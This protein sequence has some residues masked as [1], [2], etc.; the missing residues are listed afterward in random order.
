[1]NTKFE[2]IRK[3]T[4]I[5]FTD[6][7]GYTAMMQ[8]DEEYAKTIRDKHRDVL[9]SKIK[10][11]RGKILQ[12][13]GDGTLSVFDSAIEAVICSKEIQTELLEQPKIPL[14]I[15][16]H[17][18]DIVHDKDG[19]YGDGVNVAS[20][21]QSLCTPGSVMISEKVQAEITNHP[22]IKSLALGS[23]E[24]KNVQKPVKVFALAGGKIK[25]PT[26]QEIQQQ[27][28]KSVIK[29]SIAVL[30]FINMS[31]DSENDYF[32]DGIAEEIMNG[33]NKLE[34]IT[35]TSRT[36]SFAFRGK[37]KSINEIGSELKVSFVLEGSV[38]KNADD[39]RVMIQLINT[40]DEYQLW[41]EVYE[42]KLNNVFE[43]QDE[44]ARNVVHRLKENL[45]IKSSKTKIIERPTKNIDAYNLY[46]KGRHHWSKWN[47]DDIQKAI[48]VFDEAIRLDPKF[49]L[50]YCA[51]S[52]CYSFLG[53]CG[54]LTPSIAYTKA[55]EF[56]LE[57]IQRNEN[58]AES[59]L[60]LAMIKFF[61]LWD[62]EGARVSLEKAIKLNLNSSLLNQIYGLYLATVGKTKEAIE[63]MENAVKLD[64]LSLSLLC[65]L[66]TV[67]FFDA[68]YGR[69]ISYFDAALDMD[70][71]FRMALE[72]KGVTL[73][74]I[75]ETEAS[76]EH[77][78]EY[79]K[80]TKHPLKGMSI[81]GLVYE[82][83][84]DSENANACL[85]K[86]IQRQEQEPN[87]SLEL[88]FAILYYGLKDYDKVFHYL[89]AAYEKHLGIICFGMVFFIRAPIFSDIWNDPRFEELLNKI[90]LGKN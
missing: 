32:A 84:G 37:N 60:A 67:C 16:I 19:I 85:N 66:G 12:F 58:H 15:G 55:N 78:L 65:E 64:P 29:K 48:K 31:N 68:Q 41:S 40:T 74:M 33:L 63:R 4:A 35:V 47:P 43:V 22:T 2:N 7:V 86:L 28:K 79:Q 38:R 49:S 23:Y 90:G 34:G 57:S 77:L 36:S 6:I 59:H 51:L 50:P 14:R 87:V 83:L 1:M 81:L 75:G 30:P 82:L 52:H 17:L 69:A 70:P 42:R 76:L 53:S 21:I 73:F 9:E 11:R 61:H 54:Q 88:D 10:E 45:D 20:R 27:S 62:W 46:L 89:N 5:M 56:A 39:V 25:V 18:G 72:L 3:L 8:R 13:Y 24:L 80:L 26:V 44:I 71:S